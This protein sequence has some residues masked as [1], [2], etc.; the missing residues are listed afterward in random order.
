[1][2]REVLENYTRDLSTNVWQRQEYKGIAYSDGDEI[3]RRLKKII[4]GAA[5]VSVTS[6]ELIGHCTDWPTRYHL[7]NQRANLLR[8][9]EEQLVGKQILEIGAGCGAITRYL[10]EIGAE[11]L[12]LEGSPRRA[13]IAALRCREQTNVTVVAEAIHEFQSG[14]QF[15]VVTLIGVLEYARKFFPGEGRDPV[16]AMLKYV[17][18]LMKPGGRLIIAIENQLGLKY[19]AGFPEDHMGQPMFGIEEHYDCSNV[20]TFG[21]KD[22][23][24]R[25]RKAGLTKSQWWYPFPDYKLPSLMVSELGAFPADDMDLFPLVRHACSQDPQYPSRASF[26]QGRA[27]RPIMRNGLLKDMANSFLLVASD[28][29]IPETPDRP[30]AFHYATNRRPEFAK[31]VLFSRTQDGVAMTH[32]IALYPQT[33]PSENSMVKL[34]L[35]QQVFIQGQLWQDRL[36]D[37]MTRP[38]WTLDHI[39]QW[40]QFWLETFY[41]AAKIEKTTNLMYEKISGSYID[42]TPR[43]LIVD[44]NGVG[45]F[46]DQEWE[47]VEAIQVG[48]MVFRALMTSIGEIKN[49]SHPL[50]QANSQIFP[51]IIKIAES[52]GFSFSAQ[53]IEDYMAFERI[54]QKCVVGVDLLSYEALYSEGES[55]A[56]I[57]WPKPSPEKTNSKPTVFDCS[58][59]I[60]VFNKVELTQQCL[61]HLANVTEGISYE[62]IIVDNNS[63]DSTGEF[64]RSLDGDIQIIRNSSNLGF[65]KACNQGARA[66]R[67][68]H[69]LFLNNDTIPQANWLAPLI[70]ELEEHEE[71]GIVGSKLLYPDKTI[72]HAGVVFSRHH[73]SPYHLLRGV[74]GDLELV[75][76]RMQFQAVTAACM[77]VRKDV[78]VQVRGFDEG[79]VNGFEDVDL[80]LKVGAAGKKVIYQPKSWLY[81]LE[82]QSPGRKK[83]DNENARRLGQQW[84]HQWLADEDTV[85]FEKGYVVKQCLVENKIRQKVDP[86]ED[87]VDHQQWQRVRDVQT[88]LLGNEKRPWTEMREGE[89]IRRL[90]G[91]TDIWPSDFGVLKWAGGV[92]RTLKCE[93][94]AQRFWRKSLTIIEHFSTRAE[95]ARSTIQAGNLIEAQQH[96]DV[97]RKTFPEQVEGF[98]L[99][100]IVYMQNQQFQEAVQ[101]FERA[102]A[103]DS[104]DFKIQVGLGQA[105]LGLGQYLRAWKIFEKSFLGSPDDPKALN[106]LIQ[107]GTALQR[108]GDLAI[109]LSRF[110]ERNPANCDMRFALA[111]V[112]FRAGYPEKA[113]E[114]LTWLRLI[115]PDFE[116]LE[117]LEGLLHDAQT[118]GDLVP[119]R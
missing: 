98:T 87:L 57:A 73:D 108:W 49:I 99:Q 61:T 91:E 32:Q 116:G 115:K 46:F 65:A 102:L 106:G 82:S 63:S 117:D 4:Q 97:M 50:E 113:R 13:S 18:G 12:A 84:G 77:L 83:Y 78:F 44:K 103:L 22:L 11:V 45:K 40:F 47:Y 5:D 30:V 80:C 75:N 23:G 64:L 36:V 54:F 101:E 53:H 15:D 90:L 43:N 105:Y 14:P 29:E 69:I 19:F 55:G 56:G 28:T 94:E 62:V 85:L 10:G 25:V 37:I 27:W 39:Q 33:V 42:M 41:S 66:A 68:K 16:D 6:V 59:I 88:F 89:T 96:L 60:P 8:P 38:G 67:G 93:A 72:Q 109:H 3:E 9:F 70:Q 48:Y 20:V 35:E 107:A 7:S 114:H 95:L 52:V 34:R 81:H 76:K 58:I 79:Y 92:C 118:S 104:E 1:M 21:R 51:L 26:N 119:A 112:Q 110:I 74:Q 111:G 71:V 2:I 24:E 86:L 17:T 31:K 100:G